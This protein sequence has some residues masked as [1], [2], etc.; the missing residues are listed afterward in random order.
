MT[1]L[2]TRSRQVQVRCR[3]TTRQLLDSDQVCRSLFADASKE[4]PLRR[5]EDREERKPY[6][7]IFF[8]ALIN[9]LSD[10]TYIPPDRG[11]GS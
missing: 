11:N 8:A 7:P 5:S 4:M 3:L 6:N 9:G 2:R 10:P 1:L